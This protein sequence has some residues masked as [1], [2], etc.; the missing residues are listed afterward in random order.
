LS[1]TAILLAGGKGTR[2]QSVVSDIPKPMAAIG[3]KPFLAFLLD[4]LKFQGI[5]RVILGVGYKSEVIID[6]FGS[7]YEGM[8]LFYSIEDTP[9]GTGGAIAQAMRL[10][11]EE[12]AFVLNGDSFIDVNLE[13][14]RVKGADFPFV[15]AIKKMYEFERYGTVTIVKDQVVSFNEKQPVKEGWINTG[16]YLIRKELL[17]TGFPDKFSFETD[18]MEAYVSKI[19]FG[20]VQTS[21]FFIDIGIPEDYALAQ[22]ILPN[23][24]FQAI[25]RHFDTSWT[26]F[27]DRDGVINQRRV[28]DYVKSID[29]LVFLPGALQAIKHFSKIFGRVIIVT[30]QQGIAK[31]LMSS[32]DVQQVHDFLRKQVEE[33]GGKIDGIYF[34]PDWAYKS[35]NCRKPHPNLALQAQKDFPNIDFRK[36]LMV[37][38]MASDIEFGQGLGMM[39]VWIRESPELPFIRPVPSFWSP[40][41]SELMGGE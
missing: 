33:I 6:Y 12:S 15:M 5:T 40:S 13:D 41:L 10:V 3:P 2:L 31:G 27:L 39:T 24:I 25:S 38:D 36:S 35:P 16:V 22:K 7:E 34:C 14:M 26:I 30:N 37:G 28:G 32:E 8:A 17:T 18:F 1:Q 19:S 21:G 4:A 23:K 9:L 11:E 20:V 29:E